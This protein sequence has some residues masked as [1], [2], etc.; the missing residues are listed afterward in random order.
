MAATI[1]AIATPPYVG[2]IS[3]IR[4]SG[5][6]AF[7]VADRVFR[8]RSGKPLQGRSG[9][10]AAFGDV[11]DSD[12]GSID[13]SIATVFHSPKSYTGEDVVEL[14]CHGGL[15]VTREV[16]R[17]ILAAGAT[18]A[19]PGEFTKRAFLN[20]KMSLSQAEAVA[21]FI[22]A[23]GREAMNAAK[24]QYDGVLD[25]KIYYMRETLLDIAGHLSA[26]ADYP[27]EDI[28]ELQPEKLR[29]LLAEQVGQLQQLLATYDA[30]LLVR[31]GIDT[32]IAGRPN[33]GKS[34][35][36]NLL[37]GG[38]RSIVTSVAGTTR[39]IVEETVNIDGLLLRLSDTA[40]LRE[41]EDPVEQIGVE[42]ARTRLES[43]SLVL[44]VFDGSEHLTDDDVSLMHSLKG[45]PAVAVVNKSDL[46]L[47]MD[48]QPLRENFPCVL[49]LTASDPESY[50]GLA[51]AIR[52]VAGLADFDASL[53]ILTTERQRIAAAAAYSALKEACSALKM[54]M[55]M[56][57]VTIS[58]EAALGALLE[59]SGERVTE[60]VVDAVFSHF[61]V[62]K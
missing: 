17:A 48:V 55:T 1:A 5:E 43:A 6:D 61:C 53:P 8:A 50:A 38:E 57:A 29:F 21:E 16:L 22:A 40:G 34:T 37:V 18:L 12:G 27:E 41:T 23:R 19:S 24:S 58:V 33:V 42:R 39:D 2:G 36:M 44:A 4:I 60:E 46:P 31:E 52:Q 28:P 25:Q 10:T 13:E 9:Y 14:S 30:G 51:T 15:E 56:D 54:G 49:T 7:V 62:G 45:R 26:W 3:I 32:V 47:Q 20:G 35:M 11:L 59:L